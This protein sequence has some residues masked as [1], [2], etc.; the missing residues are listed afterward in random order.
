MT[1]NGVQQE[2]SALLSCKYLDV[3]SDSFQWSVTVYVGNTL[4][5]K[6][7]IAFKP[8]QLRARVFKLHWRSQNGAYYFTGKIDDFKVRTSAI[9]P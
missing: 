3:F 1:I 7:S 8:V 5:D 2:L 4:V 6:N 9:Q